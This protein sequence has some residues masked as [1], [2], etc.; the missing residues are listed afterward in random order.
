MVASVLFEIVTRDLID[1]AE[2]A[3]PFYTK[4]GSPSSSFPSPTP[5]NCYFYT[6]FALTDF[7]LSNSALT[8]IKVSNLVQ[9]LKS[10]VSTNSSRRPTSSL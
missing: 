4:G 5:Y 7:T 2:I 9:S 6:N 3:H 8:N 1:K 10:K